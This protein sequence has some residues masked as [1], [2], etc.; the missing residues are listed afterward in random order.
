MYCWIEPLCGCSICIG[1]PRETLPKLVLRRAP[2]QAANLTRSSPTPI[3]WLLRLF[4]ESK[5][6]RVVGG[7]LIEAGMPPSWSHSCRQFLT[8]I[9]TLAHTQS[10][11]T[12]P[13]Q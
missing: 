8:N 4:L 7:I 1:P 12:A 5:N 9:Q 2:I 6:G 3:L 10:E 13:V 11:K